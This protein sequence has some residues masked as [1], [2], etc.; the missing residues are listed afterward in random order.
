MTPEDRKQIG[1]AFRKVD[2]ALMML[3]TAQGSHQMVGGLKTWIAVGEALLA[4]RESIDDICPEE[5]PDAET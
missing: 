4:V 2:K 3:A 5:A 1:T